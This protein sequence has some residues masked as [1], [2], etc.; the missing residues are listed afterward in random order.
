MGNHSDNIVAAA[1]GKNRE[2]SLAPGPQ[3]ALAFREYT[4]RV[5]SRAAGRP[6]SEEE[7]DQ[8]IED[9]GRFLHAL[10]V[11]NGERT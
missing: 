8:I 1:A 4:R 11:R 2:I 6:L 3:D 7:A 10:G 5:W 9:F